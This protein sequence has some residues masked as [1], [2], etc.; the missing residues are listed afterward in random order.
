MGVTGNSIF[1]ENQYS[2]TAV[3]ADIFVKMACP[4]VGVDN[5]LGS[6]MQEGAGEP[7]M[8]DMLSGPR[9]PLTQACQWC[10]WATVTVD[11]LRYSYDDIGKN[12]S[13][14]PNDTRYA[15]SMLT[16]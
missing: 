11:L 6:L 16:A 9:A 1:D 3:E 13:L 14:A 10:G 8:L 15:Y 5:S 12:H 4:A 7:Q 2:A